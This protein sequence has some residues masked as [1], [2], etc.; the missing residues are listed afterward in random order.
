MSLEELEAATEHDIISGEIVKAGKFL[1]IADF[2]RL[3]LEG[4][5]PPFCGK[6][7]PR[8]SPIVPVGNR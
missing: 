2:Q 8:R 4:N 6:S 1:Q 5:R 7:E 3:H